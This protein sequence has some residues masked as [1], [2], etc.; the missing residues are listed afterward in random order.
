MTGRY[1]TPFADYGF[2]K[3]FGTEENKDLLISLLNAIIADDDPISDLN[4]A[5]VEQIGDIIGT[6]TNYFDVFC[7]THSG[8][9][10]IVEMQNTWKPFFK[11]RTV[12]Y[13]AK[14]IRDQGKVGIQKTR[15]QLRREKEIKRAEDFL[16]E[17]E[18]KREREFKKSG[19]PWN[20]RL[21]NVYLVAIMNFV[22]PY[23]E[24]PIDSYFHKIKLMDVE[25]HHVFYDK[26][27]LIYI[28]MPKL[29]NVNF[30]LDTMRDKWMY[31]LNHLYY[32]DEYPEELH[33]D[34]FKK[35]FEQAELARY[36]PEQQLA[37]E[38]SEKVYLDSV[39]D[40]EGAHILGKEE[41]LEEG[42]AQGKLEIALRMRQEGL[43]DAI[44]ERLT[45]ISKDE[46]EK[47]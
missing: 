28:E 16:K 38:R 34:I 41:G 39:N 18:E 21:E 27:T 43:D 35:L 14:P 9:Q 33:D 47:G 42:L 31:A 19:K 8:R 12:Y 37:Y 29:E 24:Y 44:I 4:Y 15:D 17:A 26:L 7:H 32:Y 2:K 5:N 36:T 13:A 6:R 46:I 11:D 1:I 3:L 40:I 45:G 30:K 10:F 20:F 23:K 25:D 22:L